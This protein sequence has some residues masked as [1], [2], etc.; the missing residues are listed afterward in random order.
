MT[1]IVGFVGSSHVDRSLPF[2]AQRCIN[3]FPVLS[4][5]GTSKSAA[6][7]VSAPGLLTWVDKTADGQQGVRGML[8][9]DANSLYVVMSTNVYK[10]NA[11]GV[12]TMLGAIPYAPTPVSMSTNGQT[13]VLVT[14]QRM[15]V[16]NLTTDVMT[17]YTDPSFTGAT[18]VWFIN[19]S[20][21]FNQPGTS[22]FWVMG[23]Y[24]TVL[25]PLS[26]AVAEGSPD[27]LVTIAVNHQDI[28]LF[29][30][31]TIEVWGPNG[32][33]FFPYGR[34]PGVFFEQG[35]AAPYSVVRV[36]D[37]ICWLS[38][39]SDGEGMIFQ[40][41]GY[42][43]KK[44]SSNSIEQAI[45]KYTTIADAVAYSYQ[46]DGNYFYV[47]SFPAQ[48]VTWVYNGVNE[49]WHQRAWRK[50]NGQFGRHRSNCHAFFGRK[51][52]VGDW[53]NGKIYSLDNRVFDD[54]GV[55][56][57]RLRSSP[58]IADEMTRI[59]HMSIQFDIEAGTG[60]ATGQG[61]DPVAMLRWSD[62]GGKTWSSTRNCSI[63]K[64]GEFKKRLRF[65]RLGQA[66]T[67]VYELSVS[68]P[69][70]F[71]IFSASLNVQ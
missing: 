58:Y 27:G 22:K 39:N 41:V 44:I 17:E 33:V 13:I 49:A 47:L 2:D 65:Q 15:F 45:A 68:D 5:S 43:L 7:L 12:S 18:A 63:G 60:L 70:A 36:N 32:D 30:T 4:A 24:S 1:R 28:W 55:P 26:F 34:I 14:G 6:K 66:R 23:A 67:R 11:Q 35:C 19:G 21:V 31:A 62:D 64:I 25:D 9:T 29:G 57:V 46:Q 61:I 51:N 71:T 20:Y 56:L 50:D 3:M 38:S 52:L 59:P 48:E 16:I 40:T 8:S 37:S 42:Q 53:Q 10:F 54:D 69:V